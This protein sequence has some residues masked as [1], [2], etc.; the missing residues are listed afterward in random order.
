MANTKN[1]T[2]EQQELLMKIAST[3]YSVSGYPP[4]SSTWKLTEDQIRSIIK[5]H[6]KA[7]LDDVSDVTLD[8][9]HKTGMIYAYVWIPKNSKHITDNELNTGNSAINRTML[10]YSNQM[11]EF[12]EKFC[13]KD[14]RRV[15]SE[16][17]NLPLAGVE[18]MI[19][20]FMKIEF[21]ENGFE[22]GR[23]FGEMNKKK[24]QLALQCNYAKDDDGRFGKLLYV[25]VDKSVKSSFNNLSPKPKK[26]FNAR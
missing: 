3:S 26:S 9:N 1:L 23:Q 4:V 22:Y 12:M 18:V 15:F 10:K 14:R 21:D 17:R 19:E 16:E 20:A 24:T 2:A 7:W 8:I 11:K 25:R 6:T 5:K 13:A